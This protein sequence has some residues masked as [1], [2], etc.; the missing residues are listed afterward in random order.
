MDRAAYRFDRIFPRLQAAALALLIAPACCLAADEAEAETETAA[1]PAWQNSRQLVLVVTADWDANQGLLSTWSRNGDA[2]EPATEATPVTIGRKGSAWGL[3]LHPP[4]PGEQKKE[5]DGRAPAGV[6]ALGDAFGYATRFDTA[7]PY[8][9]MTDSHWCIDV[10]D[11]PLYN[12]IVD[13][14]TV[15]APAVQGS[16]EPMRRDLHAEGDQRY[17]AGFVIQHN[18]GNTPGAGSCIFAHLWKAPGEATAGCTAM[19]ESAMSGL[20]GWLQPALQPV[21]VLLPE[22]EYTRLQKAWRLPDIEI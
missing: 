11:S 13:A 9:P 21:F 7:L 6:F 3:G 18:P 5:G 4:Q 10:A 15:G 16:T 20:L 14:R 22:S 17:R 12:Q 2:W 8:K 1:E 19:D